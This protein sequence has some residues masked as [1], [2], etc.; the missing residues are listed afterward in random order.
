MN[1]VEEH[2]RSRVLE[3]TTNYKNDEDPKNI[4]DCEFPSQKIRKLHL[5]NPHERF[6][7]FCE[8]VS[9]RL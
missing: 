9:V 3:D 2:I 8:K 7:I 6:P 4:E 5:S 1:F